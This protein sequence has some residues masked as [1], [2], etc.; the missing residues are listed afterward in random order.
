[1]L[2]GVGMVRE[3]VPRSDDSSTCL[4]RSFQ[5]APDDEKRGLD[6]P[7]AQDI[8]K[9]FH[10]RW[11]RTVIKCQGDDSLLRLHPRHKPAAQLSR[12]R[13]RQPIGERGS[14]KRYDN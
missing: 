11:G 14:G 3:F 9:F 2:M 6:V 13:S 8:E 12:P 5:L 1:M 7:S 10:L 4:G